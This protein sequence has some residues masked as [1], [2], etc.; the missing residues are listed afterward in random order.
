MKKRVRGREGEKF[1]GDGQQ[2][3]VA[4]DSCDG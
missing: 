3:D 1:E 2:H 4:G